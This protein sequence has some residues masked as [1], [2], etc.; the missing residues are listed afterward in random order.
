MTKRTLI[1]G[2]M[3]LGSLSIAATPEA[4]AWNVDAP[5]TEVSFSVKHFFTPVTGEFEQFDVALAYDRANPENSS[6]RVRIPVTSVQTGNEKRNN[7]LLSEDFFEA[8]ANPD[9]TFVS[10]SVTRV[11]DGRLVVRGPL[12]IK[13]VTREVELPVKVL[14]VMDVAPE[15]QE[16]LGAKQI[17]SFET[18]LSVDRRDFG[19]GVGSWAATAVVG[20]NVDIRIAVE[21]NR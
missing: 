20:A 6:V 1:A 9:I 14:G 7:H 11:A 15:M 21:A 4:P 8:D 2:A 12:T 13:G 10:T 5:H 17:A 19:V 16:M 18:T 3:A